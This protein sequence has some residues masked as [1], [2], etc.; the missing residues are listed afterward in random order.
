MRKHKVQSLTQFVET[1]NPTHI[2]N[3]HDQVDLKGLTNMD[4][5]TFFIGAVNKH[6]K[7]NYTLADEAAKIM[8]LLV[9]V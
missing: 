7:Y 8:I 3:N 5:N 1:L 2:F 9:V 4:G 6:I